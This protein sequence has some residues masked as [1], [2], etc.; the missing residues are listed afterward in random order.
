MLRLFVKSYKNKPIQNKILKLDLVS[1]GG[2]LVVGLEIG[3]AGLRVGFH[4]GLAGLPAGGAHLSVLVCELEGLNKTKSFIDISA[5]RKIIDSNLSQNLVFV[6]DKQTTEADTVRFLKNAIGPA[7]GHRFV[8]QQRN[9][10][11]TQTSSFPGFLNPSQVGEVRISR[12]GDD[13]TADLAEF[14]GS[15]REGNDLSRADKGEVQGIEEQN[16]I[17]A[18]VIFQVNIDKLSVDDSGAPEVGSGHSRLQSHFFGL[19]RSLVYLL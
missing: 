13:F 9:L 3:F 19:G 12:A 7:D 6:N 11:F 10:H 16:N 8:R 17:L 15:V 1:E 5:N 4:G 2:F 14:L 18:L